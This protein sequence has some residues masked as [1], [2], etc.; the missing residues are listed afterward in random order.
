[1][2]RVLELL[3]GVIGGVAG[4]LTPWLLLFGPGSRYIKS[5]TTCTGV[6]NGVNCTST[7]L[8]HITTGAITIDIFPLSMGLLGVAAVLFVV[9]AVSAA[10]HAATRPSSG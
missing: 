3:A 6:P 10:L 2:A 7:G 9:V 1:M 8:D 5:V 4:L